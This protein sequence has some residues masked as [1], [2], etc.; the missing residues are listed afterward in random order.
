MRDL[1]P[2]H[3]PLLLNIKEAAEKVCTNTYGMQPNTTRIF[4][5]YH[6]SYCEDYLAV[7]W[8]SSFVRLL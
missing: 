5:H 6:P 4:V 2:K 7:V 8:V 1:E 3:I